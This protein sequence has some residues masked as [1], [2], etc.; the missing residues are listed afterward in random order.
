MKRVLIADD[1]VLVC[2]FLSQIID[3]EACGYE[4]VGTARDGSQ[5]LAMIRELQP[6]I[7]ITDIEMPVMDGIE[8]VRQV[9]KTGNQLKIL[10]L[11]CHDDFAHVR[12][13]MRAGADE[14]FLKDELTGKKLLE[15]LQSFSMELAVPG[16]RTEEEQRNRKEAEEKHLQ[17]LLEG[18]ATDSSDSGY[19]AVLAVHVT[20][21]EERAALRTT[22]QRENFY[23][24]FAS[25][26][27]EQIPEQKEGAVC[28][29]RGGWFALLVKKGGGRSRQDRQ[30][31]L[32]ETGNRILHQADKQF[33]LQVRIG[34]AELEDCGN[35]T[36]AAWERARELQGYA[37]YENRQFFCSWQYAPMGTALP[38]EAE[39][40][41]SH[42]EEWMLKEERDRI[43]SAAEQALESFRREK[44][45]EA[46]VAAWLRSADGIFRLEPRALPKQFT[47]LKDLGGEYEEA[48]VR[49]H[50]QQHLYSDSIEAVVRYIEENYRNNLT[51]QSAADAVHLT[52]TYLSFMF[53]KETDVTFSEYLQNCRIRHARELLTGTDMKIREIGELVGYNDY[54]HFCKTFK[55]AVGMT[56]QEY[57]KQN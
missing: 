48:C 27:R 40:F 16:D 36:A 2:R 25:V 17:Q 53:H 22:E 19:E 39:A 46:S 56:P 24:S 37:F 35:D 44:T 10:I 13:G 42:A 23:R 28:H 4:L 5:A 3:W 20:E 26:L 14:Y 30:Y 49:R 41:L 33:E 57:R 21:Y 32:Q 34:A 47:L 9:R 8:L 7:L 31:L 38:A 1:D 45:K 15:L 29:V 51:L 11:S 50:R 18:T 55:K 52:P 54:R 12:E 6:Q 43:R